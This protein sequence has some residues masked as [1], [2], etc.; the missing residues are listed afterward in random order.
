MIDILIENE[1]FACFRISMV[2]LTLLEAC[3]SGAFIFCLLVQ[4]YISLFVHLRLAFIPLDDVREHPLEPLSVILY[5]RNALESLKNHLQKII[6]QDYPDFE[7][8]VV[9]DRSWDGT[10]DFLSEYVKKTVRVKVVTIREG[11][12]F[13]AGKKFAVTMGIKAASYDWLVLTEA[14]CFPA[15][16]NWLKGMQQPADPEVEIILGYSPCQKRKGWFNV[17]LRL[18]T[19]FTAVNYLS[20]AWKGMPYMGVGRNLAYKKSLFFSRKGFAAHMHISAGDDNLFVNKHA[21]KRNTEIRI[22]PDT[23]VWSEANFSLMHYLRQRK[24]RQ[25]AQKLYQQRHKMMLTLQAIFQFSF[26]LFGVLALCFPE[27]RYPAIGIF[28]GYALIRGTIYAK[29]FN[30][31]GYPELKWWLPLLE[32]VWILFLTLTAFVSIFVKEKPVWSKL[33]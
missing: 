13:I 25:E 9:D 11:E 27:T 4:L 17:M 26:Y 3:I 6:E 28:A 12:K 1:N 7:V 16:S 20:F 30:R 14:G 33:N 15:S 29:L 5:S 2:E 10:A 22:H 24:A 18:D 19:F 8:I 32:W 31:L 21:D 23:Q